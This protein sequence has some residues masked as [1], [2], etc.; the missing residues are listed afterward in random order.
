[1]DVGAW[2]SGSGQCLFRVWAPRQKSVHLKIVSPGEKVFP[3]QKGPG[4]CWQ[5]TVDHVSPDARYMYVI[6]NESAW[7]DP[8][9]F[10]QPSGVHGPSSVVD[11]SVFPWQ[12]KAW[13]GRDLCDMILYELHVGTFSPEGTFQGLIDRLDYLQKLGIN[14]IEI[15][16]VAQFPGER[17]WGYDGVYPFAVQ[18]SYGGPEG[19]KRCVD[20]CHRKGFS[21]I[22]DVVYNHLGPEGNYFGKF[23]PYFTDRYQTP[24]GKAVN[25]DGAYSDGVRNYFIQNALYWFKYYHVD[26]LRLDAVHGIYDRSAKNILRDIAEHV[27]NYA[28]QSGRKAVLIAES[29]LND[30]R[31][32]QERD[33][34]GDGLHA[35]WCDDFHHALHA[36]ITGETEGYYQDYGTMEQLVKAYKEGFVYSWQYSS[37]RKKYYGSS[38]RSIPAEKFVVFTQNHD[39]V[40]N[41]MSGDRLAQLV[42][43]EAAKL[44]AGA[45]FVAPYVPMLFMGEEYAEAAPF[46]YFVSHSDQNLIQA[47]REGRKREFDSFHWQGGVPDPQDPE[48]FA[49]SKLIWDILSAGQHAAMFSFYQTLIRMRKNIP[50]LKNLNKENL[51]VI[52]ITDKIVQLKRHH[53]H[54]AVMSFMNFSNEVQ[55]MALTHIEGEYQKVLDSA[56][57]MWLGS[58]QVAPEKIAKGETLTLQPWH[59]VVFDRDMTV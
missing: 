17:N 3:M 49:R 44:A 11:H 12:D 10:F 48:T 14:T 56:D 37:F 55:T 20:A 16:P 40:G 1:M 39:Q 29:D 41:R 47:V 33:H 9:S 13:K 23:A 58:G 21:V 27:D 50:A 5:A 30:V 24:W 19:L 2:Y 25:Y 53:H 52:P 31:I 54:N 32:L 4:G 35:Q 28:S 36:V 7:P 57:T 46:L 43:F 34:S 22:L 38:S 59:F 42:S 6:D 8:A 18:S 15:M 51:N 26:A 45:L